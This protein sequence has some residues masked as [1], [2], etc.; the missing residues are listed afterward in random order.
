MKNKDKKKTILEIII[1][2]R[3]ITI[4]VLFAMI[5]LVPLIIDLVYKSGQNQVRWRTTFYSS[6]VLAYTIGAFSFVA[7]I[8]LAVLAHYQTEKLHKEQERK[9]NLLTKRDTFVFLTPRF[10]HLSFLGNYPPTGKSLMMKEHTNNK[11]LTNIALNF[12]FKMRASRDM[13]VNK[14]KISDFNV[15]IGNRMFC[16]ENQYRINSFDVDVSAIRWIEN[17]NV[18]HIIY[19]QVYLSACEPHILCS[20]ENI[21]GATFNFYVT[22]IN[23]F[24]VAVECLN[25]FVMKDSKSIDDLKSYTKILSMDIC[26]EV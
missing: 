17:D 26:D 20:D 8:Y 21:A 23:P 18:D 10:I 22:Y 11:N 16:A 24:N 25:V 3:F 7:T 15:K 19:L 6:D 4:C 5:V 9:D 1:K 13:I 2:H 14:A 12:Q